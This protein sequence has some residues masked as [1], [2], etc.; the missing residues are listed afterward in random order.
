MRELFRRFADRTAT[1][2]GSPWTFAVSVILSVLWLL[3]GPLFHFSDTWQLTMNTIASQLTF[4]AA[5]LLQNTQN[6]DTRALHLKLD[7][8]LRAQEGARTSLINLESFSDA[9]L[10][11]LQEEFERL[12]QRREAG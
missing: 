10:D 8:L 2:V 9:E 11:R 7:E 1:A 6:R 3:V 12:R 5:F 4:L